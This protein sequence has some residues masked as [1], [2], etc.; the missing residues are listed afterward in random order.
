M[1]ASF[2]ETDA[3]KD[4]YAANPRD[5]FVPDFGA[6]EDVKNVA[7][8]ISGS[9][10]A[11]GKTM[12]ASFKAT[13]ASVNPRNYVVP[14]FGVDQDIINVTTS[15][16]NTEKK[17]NK[18]FTADFGAQSAAVNPR[19]YTVPHFGI[20]EDIKNVNNSLKVTEKA[21]NHQ[22][23]PTQ[24]A[25]G[26]WNTPQAADNASYGYNQNQYINNSG[27]VQLDAEEGSDPICASSG[28]N[29][30]KH[31]V[32]ETHPMDYPVPDFGQDHDIKST[33]SNEKIA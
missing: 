2:G 13:S 29:Q 26:Y 24:D 33:I 22:W 19:G 7:A 6:D 1:N 32:V 10:A 31:P 28:C 30:Y 5:Y 4:N 9:E 8:A 14:D 16:N 25:N 21:L 11:L 18:T 23:K 27:L 17:L 15:I 3:K 20:D 12:T